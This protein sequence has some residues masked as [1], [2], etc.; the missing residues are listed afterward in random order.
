VGAGE[1]SAVVS[2]ELETYFEAY[3]RLTLPMPPS[4]NTR[5]VG[6]GRNT[7]HS[8]KYEAFLKRVMRA[9]AEGQVEELTGPVVSHVAIYYHPSH[10]PDCDN[11]LKTVHDA[12]QGWAYPDDALI[13]AGSYEKNPDKHNPRVEVVIAQIRTV[14]E[15]ETQS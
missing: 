14:P 6:T 5:N 2:S 9:C 11:V 15:R 13:V 4:G 7:R 1:G 8:A 12:L 10:E 3:I